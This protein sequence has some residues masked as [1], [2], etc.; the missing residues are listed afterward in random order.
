MTS[1]TIIHGWIDR[2][3]V[4]PALFV[5]CFFSHMSW[6]QHLPRFDSKLPLATLY[7]GRESIARSAWCPIWHSIQVPGQFS[8]IFFKDLLVCHIWLGLWFGIVRLQRGTAGFVCTEVDFGSDWELLEDSSSK[9]SVRSLRRNWFLDG[10]S[11]SHDTEIG[12]HEESIELY[13]YFNNQIEGVQLYWYK[14]W[15]D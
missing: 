3:I 13:I 8:K 4:Q 10:D 14:Q 2:K 6:L 5:I 15:N 12:K 1:F 11:F 7:P 9:V